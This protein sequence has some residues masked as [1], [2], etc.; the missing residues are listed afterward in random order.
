MRARESERERFWSQQA[1]GLVA[2][3]GPAPTTV[4]SNMA[5]TAAAWSKV[6]PVHM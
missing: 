3:S 5:L 6:Q 4:F 1:A 2:P